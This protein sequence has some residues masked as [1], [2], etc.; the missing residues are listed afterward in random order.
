M[1][2]CS[3]LI[4]DQIF[5]QQVRVTCRDTLIVQIAD[6]VKLLASSYRYRE[7]APPES[8]PL[9]DREG[10]AGFGQN[11]LADEQSYKLVL[12]N[13]ADLAGLPDFVRG[14][15]LIICEGMYGDPGQVD[16]AIERG[17]M[18]FAEAAGIAVENGIRTDAQGRTS[19]AHVWAAGD[20]VESHDRI[21]QAWT[22]VP[23]GTHAN[24]QGTV[25]GANLIAV[26]GGNAGD[27]ATCSLEVAATTDTSKKVTRANA[28]RYV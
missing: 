28:A 22:Y 25:A 5:G 14:S 15:D 11:V 27:E 9:L 24:K 2:I 23:L 6:A 26:F 13:E 18:T 8:Q 20:C 17:H 1:N 19:A 3:Y 12:E 7:P 21:A 10:R 4:V 16:R